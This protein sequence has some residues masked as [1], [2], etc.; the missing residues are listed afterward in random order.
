MNKIKLLYALESAGSGT[1]KHVYYLSTMLDNKM[2][3]ITVVIPHEQYE[4][5]TSKV[6]SLLK[7]NGVHVEKIYMVKHISFIKDITAL[8]KICLYLKKNRFDIVHAHSSKAGALFRIA[9]FLTKTSVV[10]YTPHCFYFISY[11]G[12]MRRLF[13]WLER[14]LAK[15]TNHI[16]ISGT[17]RIIICKDS[18]IPQER[19]SVINNAILPKEYK[20]QNPDIIKK[21]WKI[22]NHHKIVIGVGRLVH[23]KNWDMFLKTAELVLKCQFEVTFII[24]GDGPLYC[25]L[26]ELIKKMEVSAHIKLCG[27]LDDVS[28]IYSI[29]DI[30]VSTSLWEGLPY[31]YLEALHFNIPMLI[32]VTE[33][34]EYF[35]K[36]TDAI[37]VSLNNSMQLCEKIIEILS[38]LPVIK[39][40][41][42]SFPFSINSFIEMHQ[43]LYLRLL[44]K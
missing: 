44:L 27:Y 7:K 28:A 4:N 30:F 17:E 26:F 39:K 43:K 36:Y 8:F 16:I 21:I 15:I 12:F 1:L 41:N 42:S 25:H 9:A 10:I 20:K 13:V 31:T 23:Q 3:D 5:E 19:F 14:I 37:P 29:A 34:M 35:F 2:F 11:S 40:A 18:I 6:I 32:T 22:P 24:V 38:N 33:G